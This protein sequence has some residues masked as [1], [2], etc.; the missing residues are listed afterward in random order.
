METE[1]RNRENAAKFA[2]LLMVDG[3]DAR[4]PRL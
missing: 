2:R 3:D 4:K 1:A